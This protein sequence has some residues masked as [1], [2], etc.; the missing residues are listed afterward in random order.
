MVIALI[1]TKNYVG[2]GHQNLGLVRSGQNMFEGRA[3]DIC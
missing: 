1:Q 2:L 3:D